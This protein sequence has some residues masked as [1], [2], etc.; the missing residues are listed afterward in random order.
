MAVHCEACSR[1]G[2]RVSHL[3]AA[4]CPKLREPEDADPIEA[5]R[6]RWSGPVVSVAARTVAQEDV[7]TLLR[8]LDQGRTLHAADIETLNGIEAAIAPLG[9]HPPGGGDPEL[10]IA[11]WLA[12]RLEPRPR[13]CS[14]C[15]CT[16]IAP[17]EPPCSWVDATLCSGCV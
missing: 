8:A 12:R 5:I 7:L 11:T 4:M 17:C 15:G 14:S 10:D 1:P 9:Y 2:E 13:V 16:D 6:K 3:H